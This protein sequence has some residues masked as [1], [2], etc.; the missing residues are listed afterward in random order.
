MSKFAVIATGGKQYKVAVNDRIKVEKLNC[1]DSDAMTF[2]EVLLIGSDNEKEVVVGKPLV[3][4]AKVKA[5]VIS[6]KKKGKKLVVFKMKSKKRSRVKKGH[7]QCYTE[8]EITAI[9]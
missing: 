7:R 3:R 5:R 9:D 8:V 4:D 2:N 1:E 6:A